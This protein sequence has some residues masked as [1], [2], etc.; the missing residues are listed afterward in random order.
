MSSMSIGMVKF[1]FFAQVLAT[2]VR[3]RKFFGSLTERPSGRGL[4]PS[5]GWA[6]RM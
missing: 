6:S 3:S 1:S 2:S 5:I 4:W